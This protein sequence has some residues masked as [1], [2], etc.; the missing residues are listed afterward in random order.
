MYSEAMY[1]YQKERV[2]LIVVQLFLVTLS[3]KK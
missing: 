1:L 3:Y 2:T